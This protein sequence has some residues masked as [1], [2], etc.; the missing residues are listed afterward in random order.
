M[1]RF[2]HFDEISPWDTG[3]CCIHPCK[4]EDYR[5]CTRTVDQ[6]DRGTAN[7]TKAR[8]ILLGSSPTELFQD[9]L[10][11]A[12]LCC[13]KLSHRKNAK[14]LGRLHR[15]A[16]TWLAVLIGPLDA[17]VREAYLALNLP[18]RFSDYES[19]GRKDDLGS[20][21]WNRANFMKEHYT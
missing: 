19:A 13:R 18:P 4:G 2:P 3:F 1:D 21:L 12:E 9:L 17:A 15:A 11:Y 16:V 10:K 5:R 6:A 7:Q 20:K 14:K 8:I